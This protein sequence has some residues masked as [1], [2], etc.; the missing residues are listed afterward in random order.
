MRFRSMC[1]RLVAAMLFAV[2]LTAESDTR[3]TYESEILQWQHEREAS[4]KSANGWLTVA[5]LFWLKEGRNTVG[6]AASNRIVLPAGSATADLGWFDFENGAVAFQSAPGVMGVTVN[7]KPVRSARLKSDADG[8]PDVVR[9]Q[10]LTMFVIK[11]GDRY[12]IRLKDSNSP[13]LKRFTGLRYFP[14]QSKYRVKAKFV[15]Y[16]PP[17]KIAVPN[18][19]G[20]VDQEDCPGYVEFTL[21]GKTL[22]LDPIAA[23]DELFFVFRDQTSTTETYHSGRFL[24]AAMPHD[25]EV[26]LDFNQA[27]NPPCA[28]TP[29][30]TCPLPP[31]QNVLP[32]P[33]RAG[34]LRYA[35]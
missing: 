28:F 6:T 7:G 8:Q 13:L 5:G 17:R 19:L 31:K 14:V 27:V 35:H 22:R 2:V 11:R 18:V 24:D 15:A 33:I 25:G 26:V 10:A 1:P 21:E 29:Y 4:L 23:G 3:A 34:E 12:G 9:V 32:I 20:Q 16:S 30:A